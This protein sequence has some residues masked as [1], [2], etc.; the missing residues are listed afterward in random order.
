MIDNSAMFKL[1]YGLYVL[2][3]KGA[4]D[5]GCI[6]NTAIQVTSQPNRILV[7]VNK[8]NLTHDM[9][10]YTKEFN[11]SVLT[12]S[13]SF[14]IFQHFG[15][16]SGKAV[17]K[18]AGFE[19]CKRS[20]NGIYYITQGTNAYLSGE[21]VKMIDSGTHTLFLADVTSAEVLGGETSVTY[22]FYQRNIKPKPEKATKSGY[23]CKV[24]GYIYEGEELPPDFICPICKHGAEDF[25]KIG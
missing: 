16:Q 20:D 21:V 8:E 10:Q 4:R 2:T 9:I 12:E 17:D 19:S 5:N 23:R 24:C 1:G 25:E 15:Y 14:E 6:I 18:F 7:G 11:L 13:C 22:D 3:A